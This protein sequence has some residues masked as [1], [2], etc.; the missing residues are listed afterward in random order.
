MNG[1]AIGQWTRSPFTGSTSYAIYLT[2]DGSLDRDYCTRSYGAR[3]VFTLPNM[4]KVDKNGNICKVKYIKL[5]YIESTGTQYIDTGFAPN[6]NTS[7]E[8]DFDF[9]TA[10]NSGNIHILSANDA[11]KFF[12]FRANTDFTAF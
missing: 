2:T 7:F 5:P 6:Q 9:S 3:P 11:D 4:L 1:S 8:M 12:A 10:N